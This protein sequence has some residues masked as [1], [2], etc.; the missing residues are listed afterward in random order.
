MRP[1]LSDKNTVFS[2]IGI[3]KNLSMY[4]IDGFDISYLVAFRLRQTIVPSF[5]RF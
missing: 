3:E 1:F 4:S 5:I 2:Q